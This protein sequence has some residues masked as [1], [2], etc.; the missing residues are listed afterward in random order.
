[1]LINDKNIYY[2]RKLP[3]PP[4]GTFTDPIFRTEVKR[5]TDSQHT[6]SETF[7]TDFTNFISPEYSSVVPFSRKGT[8]L[9][10]NHFDYFSIYTSA[11]SFIK[12]CLFKPGVSSNSQPRWT[13]DDNIFIFLIDN[14]IWYHN[15]KTAETKK[16]FEFKE[17]NKI[18]TLGEADLSFDG[19][20]LP[21]IGDNKDI[22]VFDCWNLKKSNM[23]RVPNTPPSEIALTSN[24]EILIAWNQANISDRYNGLELYDRDLK[25]KFQ[26][27]QATGHMD[28]TDTNLYW[29]GSA[30][31]KAN[32]NSVFEID[33]ITN[34]RNEII[35]FDW[36]LAEHVSCAQ[37]DYVYIETY[38]NEILEESEWP[39]YANEI[40]RVNLKTQNIERICHHRSLPVDTYTYQPKTSTNLL[41]DKIVFA[42]NF[43][44]RPHEE[45][46]DTYFVDL[47]NVMSFSAA[48]P[49]TSNE[50][51]KKP[52]VR[53]TYNGKILVI[54]EE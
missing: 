36:L 11:G 27:T 10:L 26:V 41:G 32:K 46:V 20:H 53:F 12:S 30:E 9:L 21:L 33:L 23:L 4:L 22:F 37:K 51:G 49:V 19:T 3:I 48:P 6:K 18:S 31:V 16:Y 42:S 34:K 43:G 1:M 2:S 8:Y 25:F 17:Y 7:G 13:N 35:N 50:G 39:L 47:S 29:V 52:I 45:Y 40:L 24:N 54:Y 14:V 38:C 5:I 44:E 28:M 15:I